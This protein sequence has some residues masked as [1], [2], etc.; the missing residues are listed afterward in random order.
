MKYYTKIP[1]DNS[2]NN[3]PNPRKVAANKL[4]NNSLKITPPASLVANFLETSKTKN[5]AVKNVPI[6]NKMP[7]RC[8]KIAGLTGDIYLVID[9]ILKYI[10]IYLML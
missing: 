8:G 5:Q 6:I 3:I 2:K 7:A 4:I 1:T 10:F 9:S